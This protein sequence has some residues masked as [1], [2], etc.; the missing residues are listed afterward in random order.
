MAILDVCCVFAHVV[1]IKFKIMC[2][3]YETAVV[4]SNC[5]H[6]VANVVLVYINLTKVQHGNHSYH[7]NT[8]VLLQ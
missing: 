5:G 4:V 1:K 6:M 7:Q 3:Y 2:A 8:Y